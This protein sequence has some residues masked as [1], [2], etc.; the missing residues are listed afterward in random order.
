MTDRLGV[1]LGEA[2]TWRGL[3]AL[4]V[5]AGVKLDPEQQETI[6]EAGVA[7]YALI[8]IFFKRGEASG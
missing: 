1:A 8:A 4:L 6:I 5:L 2:S 7:I 3:I